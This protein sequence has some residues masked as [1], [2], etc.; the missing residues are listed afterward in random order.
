MRNVHG[1]AG[2]KHLEARVECEESL[3]EVLFCPKAEIVHHELTGIV[4]RQEYVMHMHHDPRPQ[5]GKDLQVLVE[6]IAAD[7]D[8]VARVEE[9]DVA[10][11]ETIEEL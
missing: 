9:E 4:G 3:Q 7:G 6:D 10:V 5:A 8:D 2:P 1:T 11:T